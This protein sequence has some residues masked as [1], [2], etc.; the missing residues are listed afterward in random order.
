MAVDLVK[1]FFQDTDV[2]VIEIPESSATVALAAQALKTEPD[3]IAKTLSYLVNDQ[4]ILI[5]MAGEA[6]T[7]NRKYKDTFH[8][9]A[10]M[11]PFDQVEDYIGHAP[12]GVCPFAVKDNVKV[13]LDQ[14]LKRH[15]TVFPA[16]GSE[17]SAVKLTIP[18]LEKYSGYEA[19]VDVTKTAE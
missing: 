16:A 9:K 7:D 19:W 15:E 17:N 11:I 5:V 8:K 2:D 4:P 3:Q 10:K 6:R 12:G 14:S 13:Y 1:D 18:Q